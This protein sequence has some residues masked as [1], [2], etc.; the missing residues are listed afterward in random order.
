MADPDRRSVLGMNV[1]RPQ[2]VEQVAALGI[3]LDEVQRQL[4]LFE[5][6]PPCM[7]LLRPATVGDGIRRLTAD[8]AATGAAAFDEACR[9]GRLLKFVPA[10]GAAS[11][12]FQTLL[13]RRNQDRA[14]VREE[15]R[16][17]A[18]TGDRAARELLV[19]MEGIQR[20]AFYDDLAAELARSR[21]DAAELAQR[22]DFTALVDGLLAASRL[23]YAALPK[24]LIKFHRY[25][26]GSSR[27]PFEEHLV[28]AA[29]YTRDASGTCRLH[30]TV[31]PE[32]EERFR[33]L[34]ATV[35]ASY[36]QRYQ[37]DFEVA[38]S[39]QKPSTNTLA[40]D[41]D[42]RPFRTRDDRLLFRP[43]GHGAL[44]EN[45]NDLRADIVFIKN[46]DNVVPDRLQA[47]TV[48]WKQIIA[49][50]LVGLQRRIFH[51]LARLSSESTS[52]ALLAE[53]IE[54]ATGALGL[55]VPGAAAT[56]KQQL[57]RLLDRPIRVCGMVRNT[58]EP[59]GGPFWVG[60]RDGSAS[61]QI[62]ERA[63]V[64]PDSR[65]QQALFGSSTHFNP[66]DLV[67]GLRNWRGESFD[68]RRF[69]DPDAVFIAH[70]SQEGRDLKALELPGLWN[71][72]MADWITV[73]VEVPAETFNPVKTVNDL[74]R[75]EH[76]PA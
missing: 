65:E 2:D 66:V 73:F 40:V 16:Q 43:G 13:A 61:L 21:L 22:G 70:K 69:V 7:R 15:T 11:R 45:L 38:F 46:V 51:L 3:S 41:S 53:A 63:Q 74:L 20:F 76:Q 34:F 6:P 52:A 1:L 24:G 71:G 31:S 67:C 54:F 48:A 59:G 28:E 23:N 25:P 12:M 60:A 19:F 9:A 75:P 56:R 64:D 44:I 58:G 68:L 39:T 18:A 14:I 62:V 47:I 5:Q 50:Y 33:I 57:I 27:T 35:R 42:N 17:Q 8:E 32:H 49:G 37:A 29:A 4:R 36:E 72:A 55:G 26:D 30:F 10:S